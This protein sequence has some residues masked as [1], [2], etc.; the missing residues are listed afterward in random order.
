MVLQD[1]ELRTIVTA[2]EQGRAIFENI[3]KFVVYLLS[4]NI[5]EV[6]I[7][8]LATLAGAPLP[9]L[10]L[11][12]LFLNLVTDVFPAL[13]LGAGDGSPHLMERPPRRRDE[14][15]LM[16][17]H[18]L[19]IAMHGGVIAAITLASMAIAIRHIGLDG[20]AAVTVSFCTLAFAQ[21]WHVLNMRDD[22]D[23]F[24]KNEITANPWIWAALALCS[25]LV[26]AAVHL[27]GV[28]DALHLE[29]LPAEAWMLVLGM[30]VVPLVTAPGVRWLADRFA[31]PR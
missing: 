23:N 5:S 24:L 15:V 9:L 30:S 20:D 7:V 8:S 12:I 14:T 10:P 2:V 21:L 19:R 17:N 27:P 11:Q 13:A 18:W 1:D 16:R 3:R 26:M 29:P 6:L 25:V 4:C 22:M 28:S 31:S